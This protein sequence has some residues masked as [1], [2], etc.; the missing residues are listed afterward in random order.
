MVRIGCCLACL[1]CHMLIAG[2]DTAVSWIGQSRITK[3]SVLELNRRLKQTQQS[4]EVVFLV[5]QEQ[6][7]DIGRG[8]RWLRSKYLLG[9]LC[10]DR[11]PE[12]NKAS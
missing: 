1:L 2:S 9:L 7:I 12:W 3:L 10:S 5:C 4:L 6:E 11:N 8:D